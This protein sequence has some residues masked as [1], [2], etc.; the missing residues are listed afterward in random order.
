[1]KIKLFELAARYRKGIL[2]ALS[3]VVLEQVAWII[4]PAVFGKVID[5]LIERVSSD[6][7][8]LKSLDVFPLFL[9]ILVFLVNSGTGVVRRIVDERIYLRIYSEIATGIASSGRKRKTA[10]S[11]T[12]ARAQLSEQYISFLQ[13]S[14]PEIVEQIISIGG[15]VIALAA[16]D[17]RISVA[18][19]TIILP[20]VQ[21]ARV[22]TRKVSSLQ[23]EY[24]DNYETTFDVF[25]RQSQDE[26]KAYYGRAT[27]LKQKIAN[28][29]ALNFGVMRVAL[30][31]IFVAVLFIAIDLDDFSTGAIYS[32]VAYIWTF[33]STSE[34]MPQLMENW[35]SLE[36]I[37]QRLKESTEEPEKE[38]LPSTKLS[39]P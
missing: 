18:C 15:A 12:V 22:Y 20:L 32:I 27:V 28:W 1:M 21:I 33:I 26:V 11:K 38:T 23:K 14:M 17:W 6:G 3:L 30:L 4:E 24:H 25:A 37:S 10:V 29:G 13:Y 36:D 39:T 5:A 8:S 9:W 31:A 16:F 34:Y 7:P 35:T 2:I 19:L